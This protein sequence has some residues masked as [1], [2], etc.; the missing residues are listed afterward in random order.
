MIG[1]T[2]D[3][4]KLYRRAAIFLTLK[5]L[6]FT[7]IIG[8]LYKL[9]VI[10]S[11][12]YKTLADENRI[13]L[14]IHMPERGKILDENGLVLA[15][16]KIHYSLKMTPEQIADLNSI[17]VRLNNYI[18]LEIEEVDFIKK[19]YNTYKPDSSHIIKRN[20]DWTEVA[21]ISTNLLNL[22]GIEIYAENIRHY[23]KSSKYF[24]IAGYTSKASKAELKKDNFYSYPGMK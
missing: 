24:H 14:I 13:K 21:Q 20:L 2:F 18:D 6:F 4:K 23:P 7:I 11:K 19:V 9:Q 10:D 1:K 8:R 16:N 3:R 17:I 12:K 22:S 15:S 5:L